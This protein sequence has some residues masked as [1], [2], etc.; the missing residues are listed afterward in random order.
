MAKENKLMYLRTVYMFI[1]IDYAIFMGVKNVKAILNALFN[2]NQWQMR[3]SYWKII[4]FRV[5]TVT[6]VH[7]TTV[8]LINFQL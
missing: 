4:Y 3:C 1:F 5:V 7:P 2:S 8:L 6:L